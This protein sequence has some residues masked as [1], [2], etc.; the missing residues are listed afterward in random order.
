MCVVL[1][2]KEKNMK[3]SALNSYS[4]ASF[5]QNNVA[6]KNV[7]TPAFEGTQHI[8]KVS[9]KKLAMA[10]AAGLAIATP[11]LQSC[12]SNQ[13]QPTRVQAPEIQKTPMEIALEN[14]EK[15]AHTQARAEAQAK[16][17]ALA[18]EKTDAQAVVV[19]EERAKRY[20]EERADE[21]ATNLA[22]SKASEIAKKLATYKAMDIY[23]ETGKPATV[24]ETATYTATAEGWC[25][26][27]SREI[28]V[29]T[30]KATVTTEKVGDNPTKE[31]TE[32]AI[33]QKEATH[34]AECTAT[35]TKTATATE[36]V[37]VGE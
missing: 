14:A 15:A 21:N 35:S 30:A 34:Y 26:Y 12:A 36:T 25:G 37:T 9:G 28:G 24:T 29:A 3:I 5:K 32:G 20:A 10:L 2:G 11:A 1:E 19:A 4:Q 8:A 18:Q 31:I 17:D 22:T 27:Y 13:V 16:A 33:S 7:T 6:S 23:N